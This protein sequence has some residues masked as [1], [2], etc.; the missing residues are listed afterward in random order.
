MDLVGVVV[1]SKIKIKSGSFELEYE[2]DEAISKDSLIEIVEKLS[3]LL[4]KEA[5]K[6]AKVQDKNDEGDDPASEQP[7]D[8]ST[9]T[10]AQRLKIDSGSG[11]AKAAMARLV[12]FGKMGT[13]K[14]KELL[15]EMQAAKTYY[16]E[17]YSSNLSTYLKTLVSEGTF[18]ESGTDTY[19]LSEASIAAIK[20]ALN[21]KS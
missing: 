4:P 15:T 2:V 17:T 12:I 1:P 9:S 10:I 14:R 18:L 21:G 5:F 13:V 19:A 11:L 8:L 7:K 16:K 3:T 6:P 20:L